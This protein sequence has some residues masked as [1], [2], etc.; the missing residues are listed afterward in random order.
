MFF[1]NSF[2]IDSHGAAINLLIWTSLFFFF[3]L[4]YLSIRFLSTLMIQVSAIQWLIGLIN[5]FPSLWLFLVPFWMVWK[6]V[7][8]HKPSH[9]PHASRITT[10]GTIF[11]EIF[12]NLSKECVRSWSYAFLITYE[13][14]FIKKL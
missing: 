10:W 8:V 6:L 4:F 5:L 2:Y 11:M 14:T 7:T 3:R 12:Y 13:K 9:V 1:N